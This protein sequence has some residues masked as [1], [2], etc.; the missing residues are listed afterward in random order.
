MAT[1]RTVFTMRVEMDD[2]AF[3]ENPG[4]ELGRILK[5]HA[6][7]LEGLGEDAPHARPRKIFDNNGNP[8]GEWIIAEHKS[9]RFTR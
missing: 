2:D 7:V 8:V 9:V 5:A 6:A 1:V 4:A 3:T